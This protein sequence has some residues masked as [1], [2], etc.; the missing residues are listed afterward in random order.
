MHIVQEVE[1]V[2]SSRGELEEWIDIIILALDGAWRSGNSPQSIVDA[3]ELK[4]EKNF[5]R[6]WPDKE[7]LGQNEPSNHTGE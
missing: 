4:Q 5:R 1:E 7:T 6:S 3:L 2:L